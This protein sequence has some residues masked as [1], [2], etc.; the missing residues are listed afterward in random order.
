ML[1]LENETFKRKQLNTK[2]GFWVQK[3]NDINYY[4][5]GRYIK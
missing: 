3:A 5:K 1:R 4:I 2:L